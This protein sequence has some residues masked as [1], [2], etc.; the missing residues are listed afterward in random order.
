MLV[1]FF[2]QW[3]DPAPAASHQILRVDSLVLL[4]FA[5]SDGSQACMLR[6]CRYQSDSSRRRTQS[7]HAVPVPAH[8][9]TQGVPWSW[10]LRSASALHWAH[11]LASELSAA[12][13]EDARRHA[14][15]RACGHRLSACRI[16]RCHAETVNL[17]ELG[18][19]ASTAAPLPHALLRARVHV[20]CPRRSRGVLLSVEPGVAVS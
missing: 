14:S 19:A 8:A 20:L 18:H 13:G 12:L 5:R 3:T 16:C 10:L 2:S 15:M 6:C 17:H 4:K 7:W 9:A 1:P 11:P